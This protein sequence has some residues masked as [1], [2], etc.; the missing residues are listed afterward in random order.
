MTPSVKTAVMLLKFSLFDPEHRRTDEYIFPE[1]TDWEEVFLEL[2]AQACVPMTRPMLDYLPI[3][4]DL[5]KKWEGACIRNYRKYLII[6]H[7]QN[8]IAESFRKEKIE[9]AVLKGTSAAMYQTFPQNRT[10]GDID[11][12]VKEGTFDRALQCLLDIG[13]TVNEDN[14]ELY[15]RHT[16]LKKEGIEVELHRFFASTETEKDDIALNDFLD[17]ELE[18]AGERKVGEFSFYPFEELTNGIVILNHVKHHLRSALGFRQIIDFIMFADRVLTDEVW[19]QSFAPL[20]E[21][22]GL[23]KLAEAVGRVG[24]KFF[25]L[26]DE[27]HWCKNCEESVADD[28]FELILKMGNFGR[29]STYRSSNIIS[30]AKS[31][32]GLFKRFR[33]EYLSGLGHW[34]AAQKHPILR[35]LA[36]FYGVGRHAWILVSRKHAVKELKADYYELKEQVGLLESLGL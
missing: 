11:I 12:L 34:K 6:D 33:Y 19:E 15:R 8:R 10:M 23:K 16:G 4:G 18:R 25:G 24:Q 3:E 31:S 1:D 32:R 28:L 7:F 17:G 29:K 22:F 20:A 26:S 35:P 21:R 27:L 14:S 5:K 30:S 2:K 9:F 13:F 36:F